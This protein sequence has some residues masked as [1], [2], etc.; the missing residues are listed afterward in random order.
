MRPVPGPVW[1]RPSPR[2]TA[3]L[4]LTDGERGELDGRF[5][6]GLVAAVP[7]I[8]RAV[9]EA[10]AFTAIVREQDQ[11]GFE[12]WLER[13]RGG[14]LSGLADG[15]RRDQAAVEA[16]LALPWSTSPVEGQIN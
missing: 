11:A 5:L 13:C 6:D 4:L 9:A 2:R 14:P 15:L 16:A 3:R 8:G 12:T 7:E 10:R 1:R